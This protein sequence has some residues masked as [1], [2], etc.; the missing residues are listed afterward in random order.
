MQYT[1]TERRSDGGQDTKVGWAPPTSVV[2]QVVLPAMP[3]GSPAIPG[4]INDP[5]AWDN[6]PSA[7]PRILWFRYAAPRR[8]REPVALDAPPHRGL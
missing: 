1:A 5:L 7:V 8:T 4:Q 3:G 6:D 2:A